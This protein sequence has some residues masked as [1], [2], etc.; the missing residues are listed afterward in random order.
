MSSFAVPGLGMLKGLM[1]RAAAEKITSSGALRFA[2]A[3]GDQ[4][5]SRTLLAGKIFP[6]AY[7]NVINA[8]HEIAL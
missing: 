3:I 7:N 1:A 8:N 5:G 6:N 2:S 4:N